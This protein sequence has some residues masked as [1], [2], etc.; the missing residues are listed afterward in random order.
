MS[1]A[2]HWTYALRALTARAH[3]S[4]QLEEKLAR[5]GA[6]SK[7]IDAVIKKA[8]YYGYIN[9]EELLEAH[10]ISALAKG[11]GP[12]RV[13]YDLMRK[14]RLPKDMIEACVLK[15][16]TFEQCVKVAKRLKLPDDKKRAYAFLARR[17]FSFDVIQKVL[18]F[19]S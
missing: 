17:G 5:R 4:A 12:R 19:D 13:Q 9:D 18:N 8:S 2:D 14:S 16:M 3:F 1:Q 15:H 10:V 7:E 6:S 11:R